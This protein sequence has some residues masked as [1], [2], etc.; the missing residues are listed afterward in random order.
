MKTI[1]LANPYRNRKMKSRKHRS[2][3]RRAS[4]RV[5]RNPVLFVARKRRSHRRRTRRN[6]SSRRSSRRSLVPSGFSLSAVKNVFNKD[7]LILGAGVLSAGI[8]TQKITSK[9]SDKLPG[10]KSA[11]GKDNKT[12][13]L[14]YSI[15]IPVAVGMLAARFNRKF[16]EGVI[17]GG[18]TS[19]IAGSLQVYAPDTW[20]S[21]TAP[22]QPAASEY[23]NARNVPLQLPQRNNTIA[24]LNSN[25]SVLSNTG[26]FDSDWN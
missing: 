13:Q 4:R 7:S 24:G 18:V 26:A 21:L 9:F 3:K 14:L 10:W 20:A 15:A 8:L 17:I 22:A 5:R 11:D 2:R 16:S 25:A 23:L 1:L 12:A 6:P 19:A